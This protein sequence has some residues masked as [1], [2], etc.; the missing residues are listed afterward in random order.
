M[1]FKNGC[2]LTNLFFILFENLY[3]TINGSTT[4]KW[5]IGTVKR[6]G[7]NWK[8]EK[9]KVNWRKLIRN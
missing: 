7:M 6:P 4:I 1:M 5:Q 2:K 8:P 3:F 9:F